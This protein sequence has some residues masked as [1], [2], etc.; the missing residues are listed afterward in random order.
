[1]KPVYTGSN[2][3]RGKIHLWGSI[4]Q[5]KRGYVKRSTPGPYNSSSGIGYD[6]DY[7]YDHNFLKKIGSIEIDSDKIVH[8]DFE[9]MS[10]KGETP[11]EL[12][13]VP[14]GNYKISLSSPGYLS[15][16]DTVKIEW[17]KQKK[18]FAVLKKI[19]TIEDKVGYLALRRN[20]WGVFSGAFL[21]YGTYLKISANVQFDE[22][23]SAGMS[24]GNLHKEIGR[25][26]SMNKY[27][28]GLGAACMLP[29]VYYGSKVND[30][31]E[32]LENKELK[33]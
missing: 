27:A 24:S 14:E 26:D 12:N 31:N 22:Y 9:W 30:L 3:L 28:F 21:G 13:F 4:A 29:A 32:L 8:V 7:H 25:K 17:G 5:K 33:K 16:E 19:K 6:K 18:V 1:M 20:L 2:D 10:L 23:H 15:F 11:F